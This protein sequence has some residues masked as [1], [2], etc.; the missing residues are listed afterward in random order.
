MKHFISFILALV[1]CV[2][3]FAQEKVSRVVL[4]NGVVVTGRIVEFNP[5]S[6]IVLNV[7]GFDTRI[8]MS[9]INSIEEVKNVESSNS[10]GDGMVMD[11]AK[12]DETVSL[13]VGPYSIEMVLVRG[14]TFDMGYDGRG[15]RSMGSEPVHPVQLNSFYV[16]KYPLRKEVV[17]FVMDGKETRND[18]FYNPTSWKTANRIVDNLAGKTGLPIHIISEAQCEYIATSTL[19]I[20]NIDIQKK[21]IVYCYDFYSEY[22]TTTTSLI[23]PIGPNDGSDHVIRYMIANGEEIF[24]RL[25]ER[26]NKFIVNSLRITLPAS[27]I[28]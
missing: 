18:K 11:T 10:I 2:L 27:S 15:S 23:D 4:K 28:K 3:G 8:E 14:T 22:R 7:A 17:D 5:V 16:N 13:Q 25:R 9:D 20:S 26:D 21:E 6:H 19:A 1:V 12:Y 24:T